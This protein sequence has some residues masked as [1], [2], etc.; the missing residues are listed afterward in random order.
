VTVTNTATGQ[1]YR[2]SPATL[3]VSGTTVTTTSTVGG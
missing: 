1:T 2:L 3:T